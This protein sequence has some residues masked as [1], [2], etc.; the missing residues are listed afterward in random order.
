MLFRSEAGFQDGFETTLMVAE[1]PRPYLPAPLLVTERV[2]HDLAGVG[3][4]ARP[5][6][7]RTRAEYLA[8]S[9]RGDYDLAVMGWQADTLDPN[10]FLSALLGSESIGTTNRSRYR[11]PVMNALLKRGRM[12]NQ[13]AERFSA[14]V[15]AQ[16]LFQR[17][18]FW[19]FLY[20]VAAFTV[21]HHS[22]QDL[23]VGPTGLLRYERVWKKDE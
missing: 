16:D 19:V 7:V 12:G 18:M 23:R 21:R 1:A 8:R 20:H 22:V 9:R 17:D 3:I 15:E 4:R 11:S 6:R 5:V 14:Y 13:P 2:R 10:D